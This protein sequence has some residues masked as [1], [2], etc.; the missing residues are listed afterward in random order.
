MRTELDTVRSI[1]AF[2]DAFDEVS[3][4]AR[5]YRAQAVKINMALS[6]GT[7]STGQA[8]ELLAT[9]A[10]GLSS[11]VA[12]TAAILARGLKANT[13]VEARP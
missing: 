2:M 9:L 13:H 5:N 1:A 4:Q 7:I 8:D 6:K 3:S 10:L 12:D 11:I